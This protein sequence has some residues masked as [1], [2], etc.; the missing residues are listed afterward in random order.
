MHVKTN[1]NRLYKFLDQERSI[2]NMHKKIITMFLLVGCHALWAAQSAEAIIRIIE[3]REGEQESPSFEREESAAERVINRLNQE[4]KAS[5]EIIDDLRHSRSAAIEQREWTS[6]QYKCVV[7]EKK[8]IEHQNAQLNRLISSAGIQINK[9][10]TE[11]FLAER[12]RDAALAEHAKA[13]SDN[14]FLSKE[15]DQTRKV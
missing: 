6:Q 14:T 1:R 5:Q 13:S 15:L 9:L 3:T 11:K 4:K 10:R 12:Q 7:G 2:K 8:F